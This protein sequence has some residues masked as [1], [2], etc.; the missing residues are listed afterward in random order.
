MK[1]RLRLSSKSPYRKHFLFRPLVSNGTIS[2]HQNLFEKLS[3][4]FKLMRENCSL[5]GWETDTT[6]LKPCWKKNF[7][8]RLTTRS[9]H[10]KNW[11]FAIENYFPTNKTRNYE[12]KCLKFAPRAFTLGIMYM[13]YMMSQ[14]CRSSLFQISSKPSIEQGRGM[15]IKRHVPSQTGKED[16]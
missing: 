11:F 4:V 2:L 3:W 8:Y 9:W 10:F 6:I 15:N 13:S 5:I 16:E 1:Y 14:V 7:W 12:H